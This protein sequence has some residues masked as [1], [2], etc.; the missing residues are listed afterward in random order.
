MF[1][2]LLLGVAVRLEDRPGR[3]TQVVKLAELMGHPGQDLGNR[4]ADGMLAVGDDA[5]DRH[6]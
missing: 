4:L 1:F 5:H 3:L 6:A 2:Q